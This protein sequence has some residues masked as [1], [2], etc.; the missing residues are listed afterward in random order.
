[1]GIVVLFCIATG[2]AAGVAG[3]RLIWE[4]AKLEA[5]P[6]HEITALRNE[7]AAMKD[8]STTQIAK[9]QNDL[10]DKEVIVKNL[11]DDLIAK[12]QE[13]DGLKKRLD[14]QRTERNATASPKTSECQAKISALELGLKEMDA[15]IVDERARCDTEARTH[16]RQI[17]DLRDKN[18]ARMVEERARCDS[19]TK[20]LLRQIADLREKNDAQSSE[21]EQL[22]GQQCA[23]MDLYRQESGNDDVSPS[24]EGTKHH[25]CVRVAGLTFVAKECK[26]YSDQTVECKILVINNES[27]EEEL[28]VGGTGRNAGPSYVYD[29]EGNQVRA[30]QVVFGAAW[31]REEAK[32][33]LPPSIPVL[34]KLM[35]KG[36]ELRGD[37]ITLQVGCARGSAHDHFARALLQTLGGCRAI[38]R[39]VPL[40]K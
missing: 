11:T 34:I 29:A 3:V 35:F 10:E 23:K 40:S 27:T 15:R 1:M 4:F 26:R 6:R 7:L 22:K 16:S 18:D 38:I 28:I 32:R 2:I 37:Q 20:M 39:N 8:G 9:L 17:A 19:E 36:G 12:G 24:T 25:P 30:V 14:A 5:I 33:T 13:C 21:L 31:G